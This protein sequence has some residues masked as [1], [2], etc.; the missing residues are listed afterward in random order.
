[1]L[2]QGSAHERDAALD[3]LA[4]DELETLEGARF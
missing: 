2:A 3:V 4:V 1:M